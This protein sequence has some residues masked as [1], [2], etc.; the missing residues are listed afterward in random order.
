M[1]FL[2]IYIVSDSLGETGEQAAKAAI[3]QFDMDNY[4]VKKFPYVLE[5][6]ALTK[7]LEQAAAEEKVVLFYTLVDRDLVAY[8]EEFV[9]ESGLSAVDL[10]SPMVDGIGRVL[11]MEP[12]WEPGMLR[13]LDDTYFRRVEAIEFAVKYDDGKDP[14]GLLKADL[15]LLGISRTSKTPLSMYLANK[16]I[17]VA[18]V[19]LVPESI[20]P[21]EIYEV[22]PKRVVGLT[23][24]PIK[25]NEIREE[26]LKALGLPS[27]SNYA[28]MERILDEIDYAEKIMKKIG[29]PIIDVSNKAIE[30]TAEL[31]INVLKKNGVKVMK[32]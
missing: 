21:K 12:N 22:S 30:E 32:D 20:P 19:P 14:R 26:R 27:G 5:K 23:N 3:S 17:M 10:L 16:N 29:C 7:I 6:Q 15:V 8:I 24:S 25:L 31:I 13:K 9:A 18:N 1:D 2:S 11:G 4:E 28:M